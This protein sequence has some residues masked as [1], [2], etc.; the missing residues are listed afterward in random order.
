MNEKQYLITLLLIVSVSANFSVLQPYS[1]NNCAMSQCC[2][3]SKNGNIFPGVVNKLI[4]KFFRCLKWYQ[5]E[6]LICK[7]QVFKQVI[8]YWWKFFHVTCVKV[9]IVYFKV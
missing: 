1:L 4:L 8:Y 6:N 2:E 7:I 5:V 3:N 9:I